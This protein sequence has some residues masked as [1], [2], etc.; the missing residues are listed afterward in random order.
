MNDRALTEMQWFIH[1]YADK[2]DKNIITV[3]DVGSLDVNG[4]FKPLFNQL[5][6]LNRYKYYGLDIAEGRNVDYIPDNIYSWDLPN[7]RFDIVISGHT[8]EH[9]EF[10]W[11][12]MSEMARVLKKDG[13][14]CLIVPRGYRD[15]KYPTD[16]YRYLSDGV[17]ALAKYT[18]LEVLHVSSNEAPTRDDTVW[19]SRDFSDTILIARKPYLGKTRIIDLNKPYTLTPTKANNFIPYNK[20]KRTSRDIISSIF[21]EISNYILYKQ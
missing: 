2:I 16:C 6:Q 8:L 4:S 13:L 21:K 1:N 11:V 20:R 18:G 19:Y 17:T 14:L 9:C 3:L 12:T 7:D 5:Y 10:P 15:H